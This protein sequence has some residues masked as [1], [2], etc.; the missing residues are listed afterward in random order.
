VW[1]SDAASAASSP[2]PTL[3]TRALQMNS[4]SNMDDTARMINIIN[5][6]KIPK[7]VV[8]LSFLCSL[9]DKYN[10]SLDILTE[11]YDRVRSQVN[12]SM[13]KCARAN[14]NVL[15]YNLPVLSNDGFCYKHKVK[16]IQGAQCKYKIGRGK[17]KDTLCQ[18]EAA[19][20]SVYCKRHGK[21]VDKEIERLT[22]KSIKDYLNNKGVVLDSESSN[23]QAVAAQELDDEIPKD[24][25]EKPRRTPHVT[26]DKTP[27]DSIPE[28]PEIQEE[29]DM[30]ACTLKHAVDIE[31]NNISHV[32]MNEMYDAK[33]DACKYRKLS[34]GK[35]LRCKNISIYN[36]YCV[37][38]KDAR[39]Q[40]V[41]V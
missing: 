36:G 20:N 40:T 5:K 11:D 41:G 7:K 15:A 24:E 38:H 19:P 3:N 21:L 1:G 27:L 4:K 18:C 33:S 25:N 22:T 23:P 12:N 6:D 17:N 30:A 9:R 29:D 34:N 37:R 13:R 16:V 35:L 8:L 2:T 32:N 28:F 10:L 14:C 31:E 26:F 39:R